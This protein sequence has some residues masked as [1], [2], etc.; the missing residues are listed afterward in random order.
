MSSREVAV[1]TDVSAVHADFLVREAVEKRNW[2]H[3]AFMKLE[4]LEADLRVLCEVCRKDRI[5]VNAPHWATTKE[6]MLEERDNI[7]LKFEVLGPALEA[8]P[9]ELVG[10]TED[11]VAIMLFARA[12]DRGVRLART[13][14]GV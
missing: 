4:V 13:W 10:Q 9:E 8:L 3:P 12:R 11:L 14:L 1:Q 7:L 5:L 2:E 6:A